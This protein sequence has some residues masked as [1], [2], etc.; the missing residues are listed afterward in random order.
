MFKPAEPTGSTQPLPETNSRKYWYKFYH[1][2]CPVCGRENT[3]KVRMF[4]PKPDD[5]YE[6]HEEVIDYDWCDA[7]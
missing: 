1:H 5:V 4:T 3:Y 6:R 7:F 2:Y